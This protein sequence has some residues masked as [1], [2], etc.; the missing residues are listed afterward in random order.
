MRTMQK[1]QEGIGR[2][3]QGQQLTP[4]SSSR[5]K[6]MFA[7]HLTMWRLRTFCAKCSTR[8]FNVAPP[9][10]E[11]S[12][13]RQHRVAAVRLNYIYCAAYLIQ[14]KYHAFL[15]CEAGKATGMH[16]GCCEDA[17]HCGSSRNSMEQNG[18]SVHTKLNSMTACDVTLQPA[19]KTSK[20]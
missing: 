11:L 8:L 5:W 6:G 20:S 9:L 12:L 14:P 17:L 13:I 1:L 2:P 15:S 4:C 19:H 10:L 18:H 3:L 16:H 7:R